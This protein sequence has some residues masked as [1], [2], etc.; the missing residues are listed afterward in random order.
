[1]NLIKTASVCFLSVALGQGVMAQTGWKAQSATIKTRWA[2]EVSPTNA[3]PE[4]PRPQMVREN[5]QNLNGLWQYTITPKDAAMPSAFGDQILVPF[6]IES[7]LSGVKKPLLPTQ[8]LWYKRT[9]CRHHSK[10]ENMSYYILAPLT[11][12]PLSM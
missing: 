7:A 8:H 6:P 1:M 4:Y 9:L 10:M 12:R 3:L 2:Q 5:W 11:G